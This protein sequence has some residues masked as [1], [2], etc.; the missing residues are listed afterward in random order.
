MRSLFDSSF[1]WLLIHR[2]QCLQSGL[3]S[4]QLSIGKQCFWPNNRADMQAFVTL[5][6]ANY[7]LNSRLYFFISG[8]CPLH[9]QPFHYLCI[10]LFFIICFSHEIWSILLYIDISRA[11]IPLSH[12]TLSRPLRQ[13]VV[14]N[15]HSIWG[16][17]AYL[18]SL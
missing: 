18:L 6:A 14:L 10:W 7:D 13:I 3:D 12:C 4:F 2:R 15:I 16:S 17:W 11:L 1:H 5:K 8:I 9:S